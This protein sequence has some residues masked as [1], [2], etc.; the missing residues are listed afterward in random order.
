MATITNT[1]DR[2]ISNSKKQNQI[3]QILIKSFLAGTIGYAVFILTIIG[4]FHL[5]SSMFSLGS[6]QISSAVL[7]VSSVGYLALY[8]FLLLKEMKSNNFCK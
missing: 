5:I 2:V 7:M 1:M 4:S 3:M 6:T 8:S